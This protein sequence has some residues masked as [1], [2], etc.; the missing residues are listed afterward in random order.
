MNPFRLLKDLLLALH[1]GTEPRHL[2]AGF[3][4][5][6]A[7]GLVPK[8]NLFAA[9]FFLLF[10]VFNVDKGMALLQRWDDLI[11]V[12]PAWEHFYLFL[13]HYMRGNIMEATHH[14][15]QITADAFP[16]AL[17]ARAALAG[18]NGDREQAQLLLNKLFELQPS[19]RHGAARELDKFVPG[20]FVA[21]RLAHDLGLDI[22][23]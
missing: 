6:A 15:E 18:H 3:A 7:L 17:A 21:R 8:G 2:A 20:P 12:R 19:W 11:V 23:Q 4:L 14:A 16:G 1:G 22:A 10:F 13:G 9:A 5:G